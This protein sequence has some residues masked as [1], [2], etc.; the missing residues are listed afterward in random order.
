[1][2][3]PFQKFLYNLETL[4]ACKDE[5]EETEKAEIEDSPSETDAEGEGIR[6]GL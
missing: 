3:L 5:K 6:E 4:I 1:V 2:R